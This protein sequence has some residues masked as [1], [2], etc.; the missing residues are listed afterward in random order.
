M[1]QYTEA[2]YRRK[3]AELERQEKETQKQYN[4]WFMNTKMAIQTYNNLVRENDLEEQFSLIDDSDEAIQNIDKENIKEIYNKIVA[5]KNELADKIEKGLGLKPNEAS[6]SIESTREVEPVAPVVP[7]EPTNSSDE[8]LNTDM[9]FDF[10]SDLA[11][12]SNPFVE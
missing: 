7:V 6:N 4:D 10:G 11:G 9:G 12:G 1:S 8:W 2:D 5:F 3:Y